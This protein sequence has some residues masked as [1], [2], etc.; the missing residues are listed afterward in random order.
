MPTNL[1]AGDAFNIEQLNYFL[2][3]LGEVRDAPGPLLDTTT[4]LY[5]GGM[6]YGHSHGNV[7]L[8]LVLAGGKALGIKHG[9][10]ARFLLGAFAPAVDLP[11]DPM[12]VCEVPVCLP[13]QH[14]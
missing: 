12:P 1:A 5:G 14:P 4:A 8:P 11:R 10:I 2:D 7:N 6:A 13:A 9:R 3:R